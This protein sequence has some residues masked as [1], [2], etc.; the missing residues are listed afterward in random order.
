[1]KHKHTHYI[2]YKLLLP[3]C[4]LLLS[5]IWLSSILVYEDLIA[6]FK[7]GFEEDYQSRIDTL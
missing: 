2:L 3:Y 7:L 6:T 5:V 4:Y 1:M